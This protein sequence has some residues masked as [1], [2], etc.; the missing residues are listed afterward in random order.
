MYQTGLDSC[1][2]FQIIKY[3]RQMVNVLEVTIVVSLLQPAPETYDLF[4]DILLLFEG[5]I[6]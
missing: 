1:T 2:T 4:D 6:V 5:Q 3:M